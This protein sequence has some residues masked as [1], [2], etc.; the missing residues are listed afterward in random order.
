MNERM[1][2][3]IEKLFEEAPKTRKAFELREELL[4]NSEERYQDLMS[5]GVSED[6]AFK[7]VI[8]SIGN[9]KELFHGL[10]SRV[11]DKAEME[12][13][14]Q[15][16]AVIRTVAVGL[17]IF[18]VFVF[19]VCAMFDMY[20]RLDLA[21]IGLATMIFIA[22]IPTCMLVYASNIYPKY[23]KTEDTIVED[24][25]EWKNETKK[26]K[27]IKGAVSCVLWTIALLLYFLIS[28][29]T[30]AWYAS[31]IIFVAAA[32]VQAIVELVFRLKEMKS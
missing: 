19:L 7:H 15:K 6:D 13:R 31:W 20:S 25:K 9:V 2:N 18:S 3:H 22:I 12:E 26:A 17:Y 11:E 24:F 5:T 27:S 23:R 16:I 14:T 21:L 10:E 4:V 1:R 28:F 29:A 30:F 32:C 8:S